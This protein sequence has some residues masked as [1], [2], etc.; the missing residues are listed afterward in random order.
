MLNPIHHAR[1]PAQ[2]AVCQVEPYAVAADEWVDVHT[3][4]EAVS[5]VGASLEQVRERAG[6]LGGRLPSCSCRSLHLDWHGRAHV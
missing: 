6:E 4:P 2:V 1:T 3:N 5:E